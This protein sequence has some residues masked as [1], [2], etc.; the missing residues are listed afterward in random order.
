M[1]VGTSSFRAS[2]PGSSIPASARPRPST[3]SATAARTRAS[4]SL[5]TSRQSFMAPVI[6]RA[7]SSRHQPLRHEMPLLAAACAVVTGSLVRH[8]PAVSSAEAGRAAA[9]RCVASGG[10]PGDRQDLEDQG[11]HPWKFESIGA[12]P[13]WYPGAF[14]GFRR[15]P[16]R[17]RGAPHGPAFRPSRRGGTVSARP[18]RDR[19]AGPP[20]RE[21]HRGGRLDP[22]SWHG[23]GDRPRDGLVRRNR[24]L[25]CGQRPRH[26][27]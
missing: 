10:R 8:T 3:V 12:D 25:F 9:G 15:H 27:R 2:D 1:T 7:R 18:S 11:A 5:P 21:L 19:T 20:L 13:V 17:Q 26:G 24:R 23:V 22:G 14:A 4:S 16:D 6:P